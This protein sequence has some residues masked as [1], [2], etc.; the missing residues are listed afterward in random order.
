M[1]TEPIRLVTEQCAAVTIVLLLIIVPPQKWLPLSCKEAI[2]GNSPAEAEV[3]PTMDSSGASSHW[4]VGAATM[5]A[6]RAKASRGSNR[7]V[8]GLE[9]LIY[10]LWCR[11]DWM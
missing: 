4:G 5:R 9:K 8:N 1:R 3:P 2:K 7:M 10:F 6:G 11:S